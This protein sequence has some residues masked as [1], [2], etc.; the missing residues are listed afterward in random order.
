ML[1]PTAIKEKANQGASSLV[2]I[3]A[4]QRNFGESDRFDNHNI[5]EV[6]SCYGPGS[7]LTAI[8]GSAQFLSPGDELV[9]ELQCTT[10]S[11]V[12]YSQPQPEDSS[13]SSIIQ[14]NNID[15]DA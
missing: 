10:D 9:K 14:D 15:A 3:D 2:S 7:R 4:P 1:F 12:V 5:E 8:I 11:S 6:N 13:P